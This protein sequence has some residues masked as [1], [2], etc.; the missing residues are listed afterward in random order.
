VAAGDGTIDTPTYVSCPTATFCVTANRLGQIASYDGTDWTTD[1]VGLPFIDVSCASTTICVAI[2][3]Q[4][5]AIVYDGQ[6]W[7]APMKIDSEGS[8]DAVSCS[9]PTWCM[10]VDTSGYSVTYDG[11]TWSVPT[12]AGPAWDDL[13]DV[14]CVSSTNCTAVDTRGMVSYNGTGWSTWTALGPVYDGGDSGRTVSCPGANRC[15]IGGEDGTV[16]VGTP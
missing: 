12:Q 4:G 15:V 13:L 14:A 9:S 8:P 3:D 2:D 1:D 10:A 6:K 5:N 16:W 11:R 7:G